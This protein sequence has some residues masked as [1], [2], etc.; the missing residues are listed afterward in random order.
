MYTVLL[1][2]SSTLVVALRALL[3][4]EAKLF[5]LAVTN[6]DGRAR[7][8]TCVSYVLWSN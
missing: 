5:P 1:T 3:Q 4:T 8:T 7:C 6:T 2:D